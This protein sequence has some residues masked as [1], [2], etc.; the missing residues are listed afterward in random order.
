V[1]FS[2][3]TLSISGGAQRPRLHAVAMTRYPGL[4]DV[5]GVVTMQVFV[6]G[7]CTM[8]AASVDLFAIRARFSDKSM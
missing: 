6:R 2:R 4:R 3:P 8:I 5:L 7:D 1:V